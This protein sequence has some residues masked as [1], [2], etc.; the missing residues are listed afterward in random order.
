MPSLGK[1]DAPALLS[2]ALLADSAHAKQAAT[3]DKR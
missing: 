1:N 2:P 3:V